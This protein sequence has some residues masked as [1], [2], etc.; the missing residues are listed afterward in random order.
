[1]PTVRV[2]ALNQEHDHTATQFNIADGVLH[3]T[4]GTEPV[5][6]VMPDRMESL[7]ETADKLE[8]LI[9]ESDDVFEATRRFFPE[10][11]EAEYR[12]HVASMKRIL[13]DLR[14]DIAS[15]TAPIHD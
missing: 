7:R 8:A 12:A 4:N 14:E 2:N 15:G 1:M 3:V 9:E 5:A 13:A 10:S 6:A 11:Y